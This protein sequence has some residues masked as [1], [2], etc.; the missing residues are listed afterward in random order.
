[1]GNLKISDVLDASHVRPT[2]SRFVGVSKVCVN[3]KALWQVSKV[4]LRSRIT[5]SLVCF[6]WDWLEGK[7]PYLFLA[8][9]LEVECI[10]TCAMSEGLSAAFFMI[11]FG[12]PAYSFFQLFQEHIFLRYHLNHVFFLSHFRT[13]IQ[14]FLKWHY[15]ICYRYLIWVIQLSSG[16]WCWCRLFMSSRG[17]VILLSIFE[18]QPRLFGSFLLPIFLLGQMFSYCLKCKKVFPVSFSL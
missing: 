8:S 4:Q 7:Q 16:L 5:V 15:K 18:C 9:L 1:M 3:P 2:K 13:L 17:L 14:Y 10:L 11:F 6:Y 12:L